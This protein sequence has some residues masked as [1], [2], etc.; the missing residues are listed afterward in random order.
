M[1]YQF[2]H[3][4]HLDQVREVIRDRDEFIIG[5]REW[6]YVSNYLVAFE[7]TFP[8]VDSVEAA[9]RRELRGIKRDLGFRV[10]ETYTPRQTP[11]C[12]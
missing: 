8:E 7:D 3:I 4:E 12:G 6:G 5:E 9:V 2:P 1:Q 10:H 11:Q